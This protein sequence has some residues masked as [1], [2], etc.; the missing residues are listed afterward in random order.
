MMKSLIL[1][2]IPL[3]LVSCGNNRLYTPASSVTRTES[4]KIAEGYRG[5]RWLGKEKNVKH[6]LDAD[7]ILVH[8]PDT[9]LKSDESKRGGWWKV[10]RFNVSIPYKWGGF[11]TPISFDKKL[12]R[13]LYAGDIYTKAKREALYDG[14]SKFAAGVDCSGFISRCWRLSK[15]HSTRDLPDISV[16]LGSFNDLQAGDIINKRNAHV[17]LFERFVG[18]DKNYFIAYETGGPSA[19]LV[20]TRN[21]LFHF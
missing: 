20:K 7:G 10:N 21:E 17:M 18:A 15:H 13:G 1:L 19:W 4:I 12:S 16:R 6:G 11:D 14:E 8:T 3:L 9:G 2:V 5:H